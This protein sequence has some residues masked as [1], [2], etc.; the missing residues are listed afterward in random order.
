MKP[1]FQHKATT[2]FAMWFDNYLSCN[3]D[4]FK[5]KTGI[6][7]PQDDDRLD[8]RFVSYASPYKQWLFD[9]ENPS[10][11]VPTGIYLNGELIERGQSGMSIDFD[12]GRVLIGSEYENEIN[13]VSGS[14]SVKDINIYLA[15]QSEESLIIE[16]KYDLNSRF[17][18]STSGIN[19]YDQ[20]IPAAFISM[21]QSNNTPIAFGGEDKTTLNYRS[22]IF[23]ENLYFL[24]GAISLFTDAKNISFPDIG[25]T[26]YPLNEKGD[27]KAEFTGD[28]YSYAE[29]CKN[30]QGE[31]M[32][33]IENVYASKINDR[34][35]SQI[36]PGTFLGF[37]DFEVSMFRFPRQSK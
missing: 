3:A 7:Y 12:N 23:A 16:N 20:V 10:S 32:F 30:Y 6:L 25:F 13:E 1:L 8:P 5:N 24:D 18:Q 11:D 31:N 29:Q 28:G 36:N 27:L 26:G 21:E 14:F 4:A 17:R 2:S 9:S 19:P 35:N 33:Y 15:D 34:V 37:I 22:V